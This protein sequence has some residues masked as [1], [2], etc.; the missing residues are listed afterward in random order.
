MLQSLNA[1]LNSEGRRTYINL[2]RGAAIFLMLWGH[3]V[4]YCAGKQFD[5]YENAAFKFIYSFHMPLFMLISGYLFFFSASKRSLP[6]LIASR[7][8]GLLHPILMCTVFNFLITMGLVYAVTGQF[9]LLLTG[10]GSTVSA[11]CGF[12]GA[13]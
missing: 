10:R 8:K 2:V 7:A 12:S 6:E 1:S 9:P 3:C 13:F 4:Q 11:L 5:F